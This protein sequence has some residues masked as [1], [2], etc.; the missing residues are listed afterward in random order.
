MPSSIPKDRRQALEKEIFAGVS[1]LRVGEDLT[2]TELLIL[3]STW[4]ESPQDSLSRL[5]REDAARVLRDL[6]KPAG[7]GLWEA[8][9]DQALPLETRLKVVRSSVSLFSKFFS[10]ECGPGLVH[11]SQ[12][13]DPINTCCFLWWEDYPGSSAIPL[14]EGRPLRVGALEAMEAIWQSSASVACRESAIHG[15]GDWAPAWGQSAVC[16]LRRIATEESNGDLRS[17]AKNLLSLSIHGDLPPSE[18]TIH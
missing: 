2:A 3:A 14:S 6:T 16:L 18:P 13:R 8:V 11:L 15:I 5:T 1:D 7:L 17:Y 4:F 9:A 10:V 12:T